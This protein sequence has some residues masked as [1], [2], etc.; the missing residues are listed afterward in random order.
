MTNSPREPGPLGFVSAYSAIF[1]FYVLLILLCWLL[2]QRLLAPQIL[3]GPQVALPKV[4]RNGELRMQSAFFYESLAE[5]PSGTVIS[6]DGKGQ[7]WIGRHVAAFDRLRD[8]LIQSEKLSRSTGSCFIN[9]DRTRPYGEVYG[10]M[11][12]AKTAGIS[13]FRLVVQY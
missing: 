9:A 5:N 10:V 2:V 13:H 6:V 3:Q 11:Q 4:A 7:I 8:E 1:A 12:V